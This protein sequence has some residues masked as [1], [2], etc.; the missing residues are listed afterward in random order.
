MTIFIRILAGD[1]FYSHNLFI[2][3][4]EPIR[5]YTAKKAGPKSKM[6]RFS[7]YEI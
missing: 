2:D 4:D 7:L 1:D 6:S 5:N 3:N